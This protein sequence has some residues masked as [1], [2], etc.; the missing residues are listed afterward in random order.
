MFSEALFKIARTWKQPRCPSTDEWVK[1]F[2]YIYTMEYYLVIKRN[3][4]ESILMRWMNLELIILREVS[5][6]E[7]Q[8]SFLTHILGFPGDSDGKESA[9]GTGDLGSFYFWAKKNPWRRKW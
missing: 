6:R 1:K 7:E 2:W 3:T 8:I 4:F 5:Q 9:F